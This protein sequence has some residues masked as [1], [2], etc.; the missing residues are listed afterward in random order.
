MPRAEEML[1]TNTQYKHTDTQVFFC[2]AFAASLNLSEV[3]SSS[4]SEVLDVVQ[5][6]E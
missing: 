5:C 1:G 4:Y 6:S 2:C 3:M